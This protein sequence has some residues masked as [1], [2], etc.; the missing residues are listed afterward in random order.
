MNN[1]KEQLHE[2]FKSLGKWASSF[3]IDGEWYGGTHGVSAGGRR[4]YPLPE[5]FLDNFPSSDYKR[6]LEL[7]SLE[8]G[9]SIRL[10][11]K[12]YSVV[13]V[14]G[15]DYSVEKAEFAKS[16]ICPEADLKFVAAN[17]EDFDLS[18]LGE[19]DVVFCMGLLY[20]LPRPWELLEKINLITNNLYLQTH[21]SNT[22]SVNV[23][24][25]WGSMY[26]EYGLS[27]PLSGM[28]KQSFWLH[29]SELERMITENGFNIYA[30]PHCI[31][32][33]GGPWVHIV[34][35]K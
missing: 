31:E 26:T 24:G 32:V 6:V 23:S 29:L 3:E 10:A 2:K 9:H 34:C 18:S 20:H 35:K 17:L 33:S 13:A 25:Y 30:P 4:D 7:G 8:G 14:E 28:S 21:H 11:Q 19:F 16:I 1:T 22:K 27:D 12:G 15:R 5:G